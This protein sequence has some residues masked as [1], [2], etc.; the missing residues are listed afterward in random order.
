MVKLVPDFSVPPGTFTAAPHTAPDRA[1]RYG[2][3]APPLIRP[4][5]DRHGRGGR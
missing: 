5:R 3:A 1:V 2:S 4:R